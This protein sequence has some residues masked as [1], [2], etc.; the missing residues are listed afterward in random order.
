MSHQVSTVRRYATNSPQAAARLVALALIAN[1]EIK[2][3]EWAALHSLQ[4][5]ERLGLSD[6]AWHDVLD[7]LCMDLLEAVKVAGDCLVDGPTLTRCLAE[8]D[9]PALQREVMRL[10]TA[11][12]EADGHVDP[13]ESL[14]LAEMLAHWALP[15]HE[16]AG[17]EPLLYGLDFQVQPRRVPLVTQ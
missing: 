8:V 15:A 14:V 6:E 7:T 17:V 1:G 9:D 4:A 10:C 12:I 16:Q 13:G 3:K 5:H 11:V 2:T